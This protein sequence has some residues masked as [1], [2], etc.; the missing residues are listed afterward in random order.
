MIRDIERTKQGTLSVWW[1]A[2]LTGFVTEH[3]VVEGM[4]A[5]MGDALFRIADISTV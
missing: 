1:P 3:N 5:K 2:P 4:Q